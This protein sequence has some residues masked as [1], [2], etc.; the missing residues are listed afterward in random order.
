MKSRNQIF[1]ATLMKDRRKD[2]RVKSTLAEK[3]LWVRLRRGGLKYKF[4]RQ[5]SVT[6]YVLDF[7]CPEKR[8]GIELEGGIHNKPDVIKYDEHRKRYLEA[9]GINILIF[10]NEEIYS[11]VRKCVNTILNSLRTPS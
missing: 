5:Y 10:K 1:N 11:N 9:F 8:I 4:F 3:I 2:L 7:Y 6:G